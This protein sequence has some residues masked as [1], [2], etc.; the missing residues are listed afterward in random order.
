MSEHFPSIQLLISRSPFS[1]FLQRASLAIVCLPSPS[2]PWEYTILAQIL[3][4]LTMSKAVWIAANL[5]LCNRD[6]HVLR[7]RK[8]LPHLS[9]PIWLLG[10]D[11]NLNAEGP[12]K[13]HILFYPKHRYNLKRRRGESPSIKKKQH[14]EKHG[15]ERRKWAI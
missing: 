14:L 5:H 1:P 7:A 4:G 12:N 3:R 10:T 6:R 15:G 9:F 13:K 2:L 11:I 8:I